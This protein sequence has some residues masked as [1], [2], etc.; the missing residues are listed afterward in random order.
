MSLRGCRSLATGTT[1][2]LLD[3]AQ[4]QSVFKHA[5]L[6][7]Y[8]IRFAIMTASKLPARRSV[9][10]D[11]FAGRGR[12]ADGSPASAEYM[13]LASQKAKTTTDVP[14]FLIEKK[15]SDFDRLEGVAAEYRARGVT[16][17][18]RHGDCGAFLPEIVAGAQGASLFLFLDPCGANLAWDQLVPVLRDRRGGWPRTE[19]LLN[20]S[21]GLTRRAGGQ[22]K[23]GQ[24]HA[25]GVKRMDLVCGGEWWQDVALTAHVQSGGFDWEAATH[26]VALEYAR[27]LGAAAGMQSA[28]A[29]VFGQLGR[30]PI[31]HLVFLTHG[32]H[33]L[34]VMG[35]ALAVAHEK[36]LRTLGP[37]PDQAEG[38]LFTTTDHQVDE[39]RSRAAA[40]VKENLR[41]LLADGLPKPV[42]DF[43]A[44]IFG[45][46]YGMARE[47]DFSRVLRELVAAG[48]AE[49][50]TR[51]KKPHQHVVRRLAPN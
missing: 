11:G 25:D 42:V 43:T 36:W 9:L 7:Q 28:V 17:T 24:L 8:L 34:W 48:E 44:A 46:A 27:R 45:E 39:T 2:G 16:V 22:I 51:G 35:D 13:M 19:A 14:L 33:G 41:G 40:T 47:K 12:H 1:A 37:D 30:Q 15:R 18:T 49:F 50:V 3:E 38:M 20:F 4:P 6:D 5:I 23:A 10:V 31:Y 32:A 21:A 26:S 29:P